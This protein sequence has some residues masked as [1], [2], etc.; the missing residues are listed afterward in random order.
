MIYITSTCPR[1]ALRWLRAAVAGSIGVRMPLSGN[2][3]SSPPPHPGDPPAP[4]RRIRAKWIGWFMVAAALAGLIALASLHPATIDEAES[5]AAAAFGTL[6][7][8][9]IVVWLWAGLI[10]LLTAG[11]PG[12]GWA[13]V[14]RQSLLATAIGLTPHAIFLLTVNY[15]LVGGAE[16]G[17]GWTR[18]ISCYEQTVASLH[19]RL[20]DYLLPSFA[21][22]ASVSLAILALTRWID[23]PGLRK[24]GK[25]M[26]ESLRFIGLVLVAATTFTVLSAIPEGRWQPDAHALL[27]AR[28]RVT[29]EAEAKLG[30][31]RRALTEAQQQDSMLA[32]A[33]RAAMSVVAGMPADRQAAMV[34]AW[35]GEVRQ[36]EPRPPAE[37]R[38]SFD[39][40]PSRAQAR[41]MS[42][43]LAEQISD[44]ERQ[45]RDTIEQIASIVGSG[46]GAIAE[47]VIG[48]LP[49]AVLE[50]AASRFARIFFAQKPVR[51]LSELF[52]DI[53]GGALRAA[54]QSSLAPALAAIHRVLNDPARLASLRLEVERPRGESALGRIL[55]MR[56]GEN[57]KERFE[58]K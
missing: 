25:V 21:A 43:A 20:G 50:D 47:P 24:A 40:M 57:G 31:S 38:L 19:D 52:S 46:V 1:Q 35:V 56:I 18:A 9:G 32:A 15:G 4:P 26:Q 5:F 49:A 12:D 10:A 41:T 42:A 45:T 13:N 8:G 3:M 30:L 44:D 2:A 22:G 29:A 34:D 37:A 54:P 28:L 7:A 58:I 11:E 17:A 48:K 33:L 16:P 53:R 14:F 55:R 27:E 51:R 23:R 36:A 39:D 6:K